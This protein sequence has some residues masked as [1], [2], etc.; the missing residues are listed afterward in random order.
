[1]L[2]PALP[3]AV[4][5]NAAEQP[6]TGPV[7][8]DLGAGRESFILRHPW[9]P[10]LLALLFA[11]VWVDLGPFHKNHN[12]DTLI[13]VLES[14]YAWTPF[15]WGQTRYGSLVPLLAMP[16]HNPFTNLLVQSGINIFLALAAFFLI[17]RYLAPRRTW[18][19]AGTI[20]A[21]ILLLCLAHDLGRYLRKVPLYG[22]SLAL[23][24][25]ALNLLP[26]AA[27][28]SR[29]L[30][31]F[32]V[33]AAAL[34]ML[35]ATW[36]NVSLPASLGPV[37]ICKAVLDALG[38]RSAQKAA[39]RPLPKT[40]QTR[41][42]AYAL[43]I[44]TLAFLAVLIFARAQAMP[45]TDKW[46]RADFSPE[47][48]CTAYASLA[49]NSVESWFS[50]GHLPLAFVLIGS[51][52]LLTLVTP[53][54]RKALESSLAAVA[55]LLAGAAAHYAA[56]GLLKWP[57]TSGYDSRYLLP[58]VILV[59]TAL[60]VF[61]AVQFMALLRD[62][63]QQWLAAAAPLLLVLAVVAAYPVPSLQKTRACLDDLGQI[64]DEVI[65]SRCTHV[66]GDYWR[67]W[68]TVYHSNLVLYERGIGRMIWGLTLRSRATRRYW[69]FEPRTSWRV[70]QTIE[71]DPEI[72]MRWCVYF[73]LPPFEL[74][75]SLKTIRVYTVPVAARTS[76]P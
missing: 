2:P 25:A 35:A 46:Y 29:S 15:F 36:V 66:G 4:P 34:L 24:A 74:E 55:C 22:D 58:S 12:S 11:A 1:M 41:R 43:A 76:L 60:A 45:S 30:R 38:R 56:I 67:A 68:A 18:I 40:G 37:I 7:Q 10:A 21:S 42:A 49:A 47:R 72:L 62:R 13:P 16:F 75:S 53:A 48:L 14:L 73:G 54:G 6:M 64:T 52:S 31:A 51:A 59:E 61:A 26:A 32:R 39:G 44:L 71:E 23:G 28:A 69:D 9:L 70:A 8:A 3:R 50:K 65:G 57:A 27:V 33:L 5:G 63:A 19:P 17:A 20:A